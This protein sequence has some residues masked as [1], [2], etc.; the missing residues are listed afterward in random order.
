MTWDNG[1][2]NGGHYTPRARPSGYPAASDKSVVAG[3]FGHA[4][5]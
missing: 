3:R 1:T 5:T 2:F 4:T